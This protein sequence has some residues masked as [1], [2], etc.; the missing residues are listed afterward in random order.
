MLKQQTSQPDINT[1]L[2]FALLLE[3]LFFLS[4]EGAIY[5]GFLKLS[6]WLKIN[7]THT[8][9]LKNMFLWKCKCY[10]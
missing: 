10:F 7:L 1:Q 2:G 3:S 6:A 5:K 8:T 4:W 9:L